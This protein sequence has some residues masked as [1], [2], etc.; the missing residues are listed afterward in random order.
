M[1]LAPLLFALAVLPAAAETARRPMTFEDLWG[2]DRVGSPEVSP[3]GSLVAFTVARWSIEENKSDSDVWIVPADGSA[4]PKRLTWNEGPDGSPRFSPDGKR[5]AFVSKRGEGPSQLFVLPLDGGEAE[6]ITDLPVSVSDPKWHPD[7]KRLLFL[8]ETWPDLNDDFPAVKKRVEEHEKD[9]VK[10]KISENRLYRF[11]DR[12]VT[13][14]RFPHFFGVDL[15]TRAVRDLTPGMTRYMGLMEAGGG[16]DL[17]PDGAEI[18]FSANATEPPYRTLNYDVFVMPSSGG[19]AINLTA[20]NPADDGRPR[21]SPDGRFLLYGREDRPQW[22]PAYTRLALRDRRSGATTAPAAGWDKNPGDWSFTPDG[23]TIL[24]HAEE[25]GRVHLWALPVDGGTPRIVSR[26]GQVQGGAAAGAGRVV[27]ARETLHAPAEIFAARL[28]GSDERPLTAFAKERLAGLDLGTSESVTFRGADGDEVQMFVVYPPGFDP[29]KK[30]PL[31]QV[32]HGGPH[33]SSLDDWHWRWNVAMFASKG[34]VVATPNFHG[35][36]GEGQAFAESI[37][38]A[39]GGK[40]FEDVMKATDALVLRGFVDEKRM[41]VLGGSYGGYLT[42]WTVGHTKRFRAAVVHAGVYDL[43]AQFA[44]DATWGRSTNYGAGPWEDPARIDLWSPNRFAGGIE[45][46]TLVLHGDRDYRVPSTQGLELYGV[47]VAKGVPT[48]L[49][50][51][52]DE[53]H[54]ILKPQSAR[55]WW[56]EVFAWL[57]RWL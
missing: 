22:P 13:D 35:S 33:G 52:P 48:R 19:E 4:P 45:T 36:M 1:R 3:D 57:E 28:D 9:K 25:R 6:R 51:F 54:W 23:K 17:S 8:A 31:L 21:Y 34:Y 15:E 11:W 41:A 46:P 27:F 12:W 42:S 32:L 44:S 40:P 39:H 53:N 20:E 49:V 55:L 5:I 50:F 37:V 30:W 47:L 43:M 29:R 10:A 18:A 7:G 56:T 2:F 38:G 24:L 26:G 14:G 16:W